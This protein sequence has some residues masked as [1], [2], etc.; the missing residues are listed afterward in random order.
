LTE[1]YNTK[2]AAA[3]LGVSEASIR[4]WSDAGRLPV[5]R[6]GRRGD[7]RF[8][9]EDL[10]RLQ[11]EE[12]GGAEV[13]P[14][15]APDGRSIHVHDHFATF[16][17]SDA[18]RLRLSVQFLRAGLAA[19]E[20]CFL[21]ASKAVAD[22]YLGALGDDGALN[23][24]GAVQRGDLVLRDGAGSTA[25]AAI[26][27]WQELWWQALGEGATAIRVVGEMATYVGFP[28]VQEM[29]DY[30]VAYD[31]LCKRFPVMTLCQYDVR[32]FQGE[33]VFGALQ[34]HPDLFRHRIADFLL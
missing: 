15:K 26:G 33:T 11:A 30:E 14:A 27:A 25:R 22:E 31:S 21:V 2:R 7:R 32:H 28:E 6:H 16:Y 5:E 4:R 34:A 23:V 20:R 29:L 18:A 12:A 17:D 1:S 10:R 19:G 9:E 3:L 13:E 8:R 24:E